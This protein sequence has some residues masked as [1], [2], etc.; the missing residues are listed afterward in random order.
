MLRIGLLVLLITGI[1]VG[2][3][4]ITKQQKTVFVYYKITSIKAA[5]VNPD[6]V[7]AGED[8][9][10]VLQLNQDIQR[11]K[12]RPSLSFKQ[13]ATIL[14]CIN[15]IQDIKIFSTE[16]INEDHPA[17]SDLADVFDFHYV[18]NME[19]KYGTLIKEGL[20]V[21]LNNF[22]NLVDQDNGASQLKDLKLRL[23]QKPIMK[24]E[25]QFIINVVFENGELWSDTTE[26][27]SFEG[28]KSDYQE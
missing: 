13:K 25:H 22:E 14:K 11:H 17:G 10:L 15:P 19:T 16:K 23:S 2:F 8:Y 4:L 26:C 7:M 28:V 5:H 18:R 1:F 27:I 3:K 21:P 9:Y 6:K 12:K 20:T 24:S